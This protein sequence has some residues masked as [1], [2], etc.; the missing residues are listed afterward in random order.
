MSRCATSLRRY[1]LVDND[2]HRI[3]DLVRQSPEQAY[4]VDFFESFARGRLAPRPQA[5]PRY[6]A[7][8]SFQS[9]RAR[10]LVQSRGIGAAT[11][12]TQFPILTAPQ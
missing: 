5:G 2:A 6:S 11:V 3:D 7:E 8:S 10:S 9:I 1:Y 4:D 12:V